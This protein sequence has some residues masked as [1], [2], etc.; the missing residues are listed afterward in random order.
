M[1]ADE[2][3]NSVCHEVHDYVTPIGQQIVDCNCVNQRLKFDFLDTNYAWEEWIVVLL[4][5]RWTDTPR[6]I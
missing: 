5:S 2:E 1:D 4:V 6:R 3:K